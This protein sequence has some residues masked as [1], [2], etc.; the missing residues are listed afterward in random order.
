MVR[1]FLLT[2]RAARAPVTSSRH[3][4]TSASICEKGWRPCAIHFGTRIASVMLLPPRKGMTIGANARRVGV[5]GRVR[6]VAVYL[7]VDIVV[8]LE[9]T[10]H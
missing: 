9:I 6:G 10:S 8:L 7:V 4:A 5:R 1:L 2:G 3:D